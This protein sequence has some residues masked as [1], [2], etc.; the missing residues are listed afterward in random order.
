MYAMRQLT[1]IRLGAFSGSAVS[2]IKALTDL[3]LVVDDVDITSM[4]RRPEMLPARL[5]AHLEARKAGAGVPWAKTGAWSRAVQRRLELSGRLR[6]GTA[7][8][9]VQTIPALPLG[10]RFRYGVYTDRVGL[11]GAAEDPDFASRYAPSWLEREKE[12]LQKARRVFIMGPSTKPFLQGGYG[13]PPERI[14]I[15]GG[16]PNASVSAA[17]KRGPC[18]RLL[19]VGTQWRLKGGPEL[20]DALMIVRERYPNV[21]LTIVGCIPPQPVPQG[22]E[23]LGRL[24]A[25]E[26]EPIYAKAHALILPTRADPFGIAFIEA[27]Q[28]GLPVIGTAAGN[29]PWII[30]NAGLFAKPGDAV[31]LAR[32]ICALIERY[33][34]YIRRAAVRG[35]QLQEDFG[36][37]RIAHKI[38]SAL[39]DDESPGEL[40]L[41]KPGLDRSPLP[42]PG[43]DLQC[44]ERLLESHPPPEGC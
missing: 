15:V 9:Q 29:Q 30:G 6:P 43:S 36:W 31:D 16:A 5:G 39:L 35:R 11:Q 17:V 41:R 21:Q 1:V 3:D 14:E 24:P 37:P 10:A 44:S 8:L 22:V 19:F 23:V 12:T 28:A 26:L 20:L 40:R 18:R 4:A 2:L 34:E 7:I 33:D 25:S 27:L 13:I 42:P 32:S 38:A